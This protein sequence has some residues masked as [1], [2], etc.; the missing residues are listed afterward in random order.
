MS[1]PFRELEH[2]FGCIMLDLRLGYILETFTLSTNPL[3]SFR[4][5]EKDYGVYFEIFMH[6]K[7]IDCEIFIFQLT[8]YISIP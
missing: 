7:L 3:C 8:I 1:Y 5:I 6:F 2:I 4:N